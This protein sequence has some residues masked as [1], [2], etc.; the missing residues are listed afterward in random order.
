MPFRH[1]AA[2]VNRFDRARDKLRASHGY[3]DEDQAHGGLRF[4]WRRR[5]LLGLTWSPRPWAREKNVIE[6]GRIGGCV[7]VHV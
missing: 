6:R 5:P 3:D 1:A 4:A 7:S 2:K